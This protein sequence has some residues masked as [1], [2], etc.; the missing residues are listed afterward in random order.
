MGGKMDRSGRTKVPIHDILGGLEMLKERLQFKLDKYGYGTFAS[1]HEIMG[2][3]MEEVV[4]V[5]ATVHESH[6]ENDPMPNELLNV[7]V[8]AIFGCICM[9]NGHTDW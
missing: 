9:K 6:G 3:L 8:A 1:R 7:A 5:Q 2:V 4:K